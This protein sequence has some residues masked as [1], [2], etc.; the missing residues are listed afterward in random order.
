[1]GAKGEPPLRLLLRVRGAD[2][3]EHDVPVPRPDESVREAL[4]R[5][6][7]EHLG[8]APG[9][10]LLRLEGDAAGGR[11]VPSWLCVGGLLERVRD[12]AAPRLTVESSFVELRFLYLSGR[13]VDVTAN[14]TS[15]EAEVK[16]QL[17]AATGVEAW[18]LQLVHG[19]RVLDD[20]L[21][22]DAYEAL[23]QSPAARPVLQLVVVDDW[24]DEAAGGYWNAHW[25]WDDDE[26]RWRPA[27]R[28]ALYSWWR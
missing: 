8:R 19:L 18:K 24:Y 7:A 26:E 28:P 22:L 25:E 10:L 9:S 20:V 15:T 5:P 4:L 14:L 17:E 23:W 11:R 1:M 6:L 2:D 13:R 12:C 27:D 21:P 16:E 3:E